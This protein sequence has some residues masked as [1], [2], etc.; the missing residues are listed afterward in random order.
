MYMYIQ[1]NIERLSLP[2]PSGT[3]DLLTDATL[4]LA[5]TKRYGLVGRNGAGK[6]TLLRYIKNGFLRITDKIKQKQ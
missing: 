2:H 6:S 5:P 1:V 3:G 4:V